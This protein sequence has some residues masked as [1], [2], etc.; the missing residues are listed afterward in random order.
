MKLNPIQKLN[1]SLIKVYSIYFYVFYVAFSLLYIFFKVIVL[2]YTYYEN[3][4]I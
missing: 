2:R 1:N 4:P 3:E